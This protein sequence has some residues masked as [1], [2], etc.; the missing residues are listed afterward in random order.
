M[1]FGNMGDDCATGVAFT[2]NPSTGERVFYGE[3]LENAQGED[4]VAGIRTPQP[5]N[6]AS[7]RAGPG[8]SAD[9]RGGDAGRLPG[10]RRASAR[11]LEKHYRDMQDIEFTIE[12]GK[13]W[14]LQTR[15]GKRTARAAVRIAVDMVRERLIDKEE[16]ILRVD[17]RAARPAAAPD[18]RP[19][20]EARRARAAGCRRRR[21][22]PPAAWRL[23]A[24]EAEAR[25]KAGEKVD[26]GAGRDVAGGHP[27]HERR[28]GHPH[29][30][31][32]A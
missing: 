11:R 10:A 17:A 13:L 14:M 25:A 7:R 15:T 8:A 18:L 5:I 28:R 26:P 30:A 16:A 19:E 22:P 20:G 21:A 1:V 12:H 23:N 6:K 3:Y 4:V 2:R 29:R 32:A 9:A 24:D 27:R 31:A